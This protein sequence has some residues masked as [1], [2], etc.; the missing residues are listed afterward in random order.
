MKKKFLTL[1][2][3]VLMSKLSLAGW[4]TSIVN[5]SGMP[6]VAAQLD[7]VWGSAPFDQAYVQSTI[8]LDPNYFIPTSRSYT[9]IAL[10]VVDA[11]VNTGWGGLWIGTKAGSFV[12]TNQPILEL[13]A[14]TYGS[15]KQEGST[16]ICAN[17]LFG[18]LTLTIKS[19]GTLSCE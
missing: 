10:P 6:A 2:L 14:Q 11:F 3:F 17:P 15:G 8:S 18:N 19:D 7:N 12:L 16:K 5:N 4:I 1:A 9:G 13:H